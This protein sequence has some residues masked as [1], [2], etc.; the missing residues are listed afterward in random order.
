MSEGQ[1][2]LYEIDAEE[3]CL[4][5]RGPQSEEGWEEIFA[6]MRERRIGGFRADEI[7]D[8]AMKGLSRLNELRR[9]QSCW[10][11]GISDAGVANL[12]GCHRLESVNLIGTDTGDGLLRA[13]AGKAHLRQL[14]TGRCVSDSGMKLL[15]QIPAFKNWLGGEIRLGLMSAEAQ[16]NH[17]L[18]DGPFTDAGLAEIVGLDGL[19]GLSFLWHSAAFSS[20]GMANLRRLPRLGFLGCQGAHC[21]D[22][23]MREI[24][25]MPQLRMLMGQGA[26][27]SDVGWEALSDSE[28]IEY[29]WGRECPNLTGLGFSKLAAMPALRGLGVSCKNVDDT[30]LALLPSFP[31]LREIMPMDVS[32]AGFRYLGRCEKLEQLWC[33][34]CRDTGDV[35]TEHIRMLPHL[36]SYY[37]G[38]TQITD[39]SLEIL[40]RMPSLEEVELKACARISEGG[41]ARL[42]TLMNSRGGRVKYS[43]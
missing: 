33:M 19:F 5:A 35:A 38:M 20:A 30:S 39:T 32:D 9:F 22:E 18:L 27:A 10:G 15:H 43:A 26:V 23:A 16:P 17:L 40:G 34:Y 1:R 7:S 41:V 31:A 21:D 37:A 25:A 11:K 29:I 12:E 2:A 24:A 4:V 8:Q 6:V 36:K 14:K 42:T 13:M 3:D 28:S